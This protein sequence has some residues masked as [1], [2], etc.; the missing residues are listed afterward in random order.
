MT[1]LICLFIATTA[2]LNHFVQDTSMLF[3]IALGRFCHKWHQQWPDVCSRALS[4]RPVTFNH[5]RPHCNSFA[6]FGVRLAVF[7]A[8]SF[9]HSRC[10]RLFVPSFSDSSESFYPRPALP[11]G[12]LPTQLPSIESFWS[13]VASKEDTIDAAEFCGIDCLPGRM[14]FAVIWVVF[15]CLFFLGSHSSNS[16]RWLCLQGSHTTQQGMQCGRRS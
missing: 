12:S 14:V 1:V 9:R 8:T 15:C 5:S 16:C 7:M 11:T 13:H 10:W 4:S 2:Y 3:E 6:P